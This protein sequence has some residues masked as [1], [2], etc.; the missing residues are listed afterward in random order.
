M[1][2]RTDPSHERSLLRWMRHWP[3]NVLMGLI[4]SSFLSA[5]YCILLTQGELQARGGFW[6][7]ILFLITVVITTRMVAK[8][9]RSQ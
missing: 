6:S 1:N 3:Q 5:M 9:E 4:L 2:D 8:W 7:I